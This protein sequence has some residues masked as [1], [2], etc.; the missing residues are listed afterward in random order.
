MF[1]R[2]KT[3]K[4]WK[5]YGRIVWLWTCRWN[6]IQYEFLEWNRQKFWF[7]IANNENGEID[8][9]NECELLRL[10]RG[11]CAPNIFSWSQTDIT[12][13]SSFQ[14]QQIASQDSISFFEKKSNRIR[15]RPSNTNIQKSTIS[16]IL[17]NFMSNNTPVNVLFNQ[18]SS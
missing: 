12:T 16:T 18:Y 13:Q 6:S 7:S 3:K 9:G 17:M 8:S 11:Y 4:R 2:I 1:F 10:K 14:F 5:T 15:P